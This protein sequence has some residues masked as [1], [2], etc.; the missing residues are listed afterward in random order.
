MGAV[1][2][3]VAGVVGVDGRTG[4]RCEV[5]ARQYA[6][7]E[8]GVRVEPGVDDEDDGLLAAVHRGEITV[9]GQVRLVD[10]ID[11]P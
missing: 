8:V 3:T 1:T 7:E 4:V 6:T 9:E 5:A 10:A 11:T 2:L